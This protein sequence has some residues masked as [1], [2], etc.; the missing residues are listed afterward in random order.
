MKSEA[1]VNLCTDLRTSKVGVGVWPPKDEKQ[2]HESTQG[3][4]DGHPRNVG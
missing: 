1:S 4:E 3:G 2:K